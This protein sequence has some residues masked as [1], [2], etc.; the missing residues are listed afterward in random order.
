MVFKSE[1]VVFKGVDNDSNNHGSGDEESENGFGE[2]VKV[3]KI[4][5]KEEGK[6]KKEDGQLILDKGRE[7]EVFDLG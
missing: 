7:G 4:R 5:Q 6:E 2:L 3:R 1:L